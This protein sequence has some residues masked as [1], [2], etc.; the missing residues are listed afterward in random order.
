MKNSLIIFLVFC[1]SLLPNIL[2]GQSQPGIE[3]SKPF[4]IKKEYQAKKQEVA[5]AEKESGKFDSET[6]LRLAIWA[7]QINQELMRNTVI[8]DLQEIIRKEPDNVLA[9]QMLGYVKYQNKWM[10]IQEYARTREKEGEKILQKMK[11]AK[12]SEKGGLI[13][14][15]KEIETPCKM[16]PLVNALLDSSE[17]VQLFAVSELRET[18]ERPAI[19]YLVRA[20][21]VAEKESVRKAS[22]DAVKDWDKKEANVYYSYYSQSVGNAFEGQV[23]GRALQSIIDSGISEIDSDVVGSLMWTMHGLMCEIKTQLVTANA[24]YTLPNL[25]TRSVNYTNPNYPPYGGTVAPISLM[26]SYNIELPDVSF[27]GIHT[28][29]KLPATGSISLERQLFLAGRALEVMTAQNFGTDYNKWLA[30]WQE[31]NKSNKKP[32]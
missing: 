25:R 2:I 29:V 9:R 32:G 24:P 14:S 5:A 21:L 23:R 17:A 13:K 18:K 6:R 28:R 19:P 16:K 20:S 1:L 31:Y 26:G 27:Q 7:A 22:F 10:T 11:T 30:W 15:F 12:D 4:D 8:S 3:T